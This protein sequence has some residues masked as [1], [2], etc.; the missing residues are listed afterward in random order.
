MSTNQRV[1]ELQIIINQKEAGLQML[2]IV[3]ERKE[4][5]KQDIVVINKD[6]MMNYN[7]SYNSEINFNKFI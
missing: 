6:M 5:L 4:I 1:R 3:V 7:I 2:L